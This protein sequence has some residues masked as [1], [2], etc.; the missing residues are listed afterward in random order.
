MLSHQCRVVE[1]I[2]HRNQKE[3]FTGSYI[4]HEWN[5][6][7][8]ISFKAHLTFA[9]KQER[10]VQIGNLNLPKNLVPQSSVMLQEC[11]C[12]CDYFTS[13]N[14]P[15]QHLFAVWHLLQLKRMGNCFKQ[16]SRW[17]RISETDDYFNE[18]LLR[19]LENPFFIKLS[20]RER[21]YYM[22]EEDNYFA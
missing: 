9:E 6:N 7:G 22:N 13:F 15:C 12:D 4:V 1:F 14:L 2:K 19:G 21:L 16:F 17:L 10:V 20:E 18:N 3:H 5:G 11:F 8:Y